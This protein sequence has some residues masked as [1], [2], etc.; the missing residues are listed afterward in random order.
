[1]NTVSSTRN[2]QTENPALNDQYVDGPRLLEILFSPECRPTTR[3]LHDQHMARRIPSIKIGHLVFYSPAQVRAALE[4][5]E[6]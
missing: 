4:N 5:K 3:W 2:D 1:M 6:R